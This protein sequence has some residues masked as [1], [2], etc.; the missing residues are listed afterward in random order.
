MSDPTTKAP[1]EKPQRHCR[2]VYSC[3][4]SYCACQCPACVGAYEAGYTTC[5]QEPR[6][7]RKANS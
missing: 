6:A 3:R 2:D 1:T 7:E 5:D 4:A